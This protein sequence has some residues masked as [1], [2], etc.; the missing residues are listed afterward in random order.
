LP[1]FILP[2]PHPSVKEMYPWGAI[3]F[4]QSERR[5]KRE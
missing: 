3:S 1:E 5:E 2:P 4:Y